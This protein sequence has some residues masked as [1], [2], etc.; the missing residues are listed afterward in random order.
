M[1][2]SPALKALTTLRHKPTARQ[3]RRTAEGQTSIVTGC[4]TSSN[5]WIETYPPRTALSRQL[6]RIFC[7]RALQMR[8]WRHTTARLRTSAT[9]GL[10]SH[11]GI[12]GSIRKRVQA[13][14]RTACW[15]DRPG[16]LHRLAL[17]ASAPSVHVLTAAV[18]V[19]NIQA[20]P[21][22]A[23]FVEM[24]LRYID[25]AGRSNLG[26]AQPAN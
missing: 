2:I 4:K 18:V 22:I 15:L 24:G 11:N 19:G 14:L 26:N 5:A 8:Q 17:N 13:T 20:P 9:G 6:G 16:L 23:H 10:S 1:R 7:W 25:V 3:R 12:A 21:F